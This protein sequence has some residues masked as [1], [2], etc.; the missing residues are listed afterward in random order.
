MK[1]KILMPGLSTTVQDNGRYGYLASGL[2]PSGAMDENAFRAA[3]AMINNPEHAAVLEASLLGPSIIFTPEAA[4]TGTDISEEEIVIAI[5]GADM[6]ACLNGI[7]VDTSRPIL[8]RQGQTLSLGYARHGCRAY[9]AVAGGINVASVLGSRST[10]LSCKL[11]GYH[12]RAL[13]RGDV[14][15]IFPSDT[16]LHDVCTH[17]YERPSYPS[18][19]TVNVMLGPQDDYFTEAGIRTFLESPYQVTSASDRMGCRMEGKAIESFHGTDIVSDATPLGSVQIPQNGMP[20]VLLKDR[21]TTGG[22]AKIATIISSDLWKIAQAKPGDIVHFR[23]K[24]GI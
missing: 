9:L 12:G 1:M 2:S 20:I 7:P 23:R 11:G 21:Q 4:P 14:L 13:K 16:A 22:Y 17:T 3:N 8:I 6:D 24:E 19:I 15:K 5:T 10:N 18:E